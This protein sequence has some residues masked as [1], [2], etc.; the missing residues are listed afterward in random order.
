M[1]SLKKFNFWKKIYLKFY[2]CTTDIKSNSNSFTTIS[3]CIYLKFKVTSDNKTEIC[4]FVT[5]Y[6]I[7][8]T[9]F[10]KTQIFSEKF[11]IYVT[12]FKILFWKKNWATL[13][14]LVALIL[15][16]KILKNP[17][18]FVQQCTFTLH[19]PRVHDIVVKPALSYTHTERQAARQ[20]SAASK[21]PLE[22]IATLQ[23]GSQTHSQASPLTCI[24][25]WRWRWL[26]LTLGVGIP[27][28][29]VAPTVQTFQRDTFGILFW[30]FGDVCSEF[31]SQSRPSARVLCCL[32]AIYS[33]DSPLVRHL[34]KYLRPE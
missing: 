11:L 23:N 25:W 2:L 14:F 30:T 7:Q 5:I 27:L 22:H 9:L 12:C 18:L 17:S 6:S 4:S 26:P 15:K 10:R 21:F 1:F 34:L 8:R 20:A 29:R 16:V 13:F 31:Q 33:L 28:K 32:S 19:R 3:N 24:S